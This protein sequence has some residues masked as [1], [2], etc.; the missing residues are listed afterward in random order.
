MNKFKLSKKSQRELIGVHPVL[1]FAVME[2][3]KITDQDF[4]VFDGLRTQREQNKLVRSGRSKTKRSYHLYGLA[5]DLVAFADGKPSWDIKYYADIAH[6]MKT[7]I[8]KYSLP[9]EWGHELWGWDSPHW[10]MTRDKL[11]QKDMRKVYDVR[12]L[13]RI[14]VV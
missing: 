2:A 7:V 12:K 11:T 8:K 1:A 9:I 3:I 5:V 4:M 13:G 10:Q 6:A 14:E